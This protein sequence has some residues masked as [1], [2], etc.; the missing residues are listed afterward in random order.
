MPPPLGP[1][2]RIETPR[3]VL[4][5]WEPADAPALDELVGRNLKYLRPR[6]RWAQDEPKALEE[7]VRQVRHWRAALDRDQFW[8]YAVCVEGGILGGAAI[9]VHNATA[10]ALHATTWLGRRHDGSGRREEALA[11]LARTAFEL[12]EA[13]KVQS[14]PAADD[15]EGRAA[16]RALGF[17]YDG[18]VRRLV[19][20]AR[21]DET[22]WSLLPDEWPASPAA[23]IAAEARA[24]GVLGNRLF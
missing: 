9:L 14:A 23:S 18:L 24:F 11:A 7:R 2:Y 17:T 4:R 21:H 8:N 12:L 10:T 22:L 19:C 13:P 6:Q 5:C 1:A 3:L 20:G 16:C 15:E